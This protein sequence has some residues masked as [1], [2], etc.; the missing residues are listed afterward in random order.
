MVSRAGG[1]GTMALTFTGQWW[2]S[3]SDWVDLDKLLCSKPQNSPNNSLQISSTHK[4]LSSWSDGLV[5]AR[6][7]LC[8]G[9]GSRWFTERFHGNAL[10]RD[11]QH[12]Q[13]FWTACCLKNYAVTRCRLHQRAPQRRH[14]TDVVAVEVD[15]VGA[16]D[17]HHSLR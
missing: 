12:R 9:F 17:A 1:F 7:S 8:G 13:V 4:I 2:A 10:V 16:N 11:F 5:S 14:P 15:L 3:I 6:D